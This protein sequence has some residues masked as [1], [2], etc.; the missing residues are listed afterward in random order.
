MPF[1]VDHIYIPIKFDLGGVIDDVWEVMPVLERFG[2]VSI[3][4]VDDKDARSYNISYLAT[5]PPVVTIKVG[6]SRVRLRDITWS[7]ATELV[8][9]SGLGVLSVDL[10]FSAP[11][12]LATDDDLRRFYDDQVAANNVDYFEYLADVGV[13]SKNLASYRSSAEANKASHSGW[14]AA[15]YVTRLRAA[16]LGSP[17]FRPREHCYPFQNMRQFFVLRHADPIEVTGPHAAEDESR[18]LDSLLGLTARTPRQGASLAAPEWPQLNIE[19]VVVQS[20][21][22]STVAVVGEVRLTD[23]LDVVQEMYGQMHAQ[24]FFCQLW[25]GVDPADREDELLLTGPGGASDH[26]V[27]HLARTQM[28]LAHGLA[29]IGNVDLMFRDPVRVTVA[30]F[31]IESLRVR[32]HAEAAQRRLELVRASLEQVS[33]L[34]TSSFER[35]LQL[36]F[37]ITA[38]AG[39][40]SLYPALSSLNS[41]WRLATVGLF[42][43]MSLMCW[44]VVRAMGRAAEL[45]R[46]GRRGGRRLFRN[47]NR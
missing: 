26:R 30:H 39:V 14:R 41:T 16:L 38:I 8:V 24:W 5:H 42:L 13:L 44:G 32:R 31:L 4:A 40:V 27:A 9:Y 7:V 19:D 37:A 15:P 23:A 22:W 20:S 47:P 6:T 29:E 25:V 35:R 45:E 10:R 21:G 11:S 18:L 33:N 43:A 28:Q 1:A 46:T 36:L 3:D 34:R 2:E 17:A 12:R